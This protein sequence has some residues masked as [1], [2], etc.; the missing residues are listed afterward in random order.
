[1]SLGIAGLLTFL[2]VWYVIVVPVIFRLYLST[3][4]NDF[5]P[6]TSQKRRKYWVSYQPF[7]HVENQSLSRV[8]GM[9]KN[10]ETHLTLPSPPS[11]QV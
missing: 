11:W 5:Y 3:I 1:L 6:V 4:T 8:V 9:Y 2:V 7:L 10:M